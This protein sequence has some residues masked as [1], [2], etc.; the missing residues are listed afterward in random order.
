MAG[1]DQ[2]IF[3]AIATGLA[4]SREPDLTGF[5]Q[6]R[7]QMLLGR[8]LAPAYQPRVLAWLN[9]RV[10]TLSAGQ[11]SI[12]ARNDPAA[13]GLPVRIVKIGEPFAEPV[14]VQPVEPVLRFT[15]RGP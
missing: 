11:V 4:T 7:V 12:E 13:Q 1:N 15:M 10:R 8:A 9:Q 2:A 3:E 6:A 14:V 5:D